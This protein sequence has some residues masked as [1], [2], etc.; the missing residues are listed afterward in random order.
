MLFIFYFVQVPQQCKSPVAASK[1][2]P[3]YRH[4]NTTHLYTQF[5]MHYLHVTSAL[6]ADNLY[7]GPGGV[8]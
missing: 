1:P 6:Q 4:E 7:C 3:Y 8:S 2:D 5:I